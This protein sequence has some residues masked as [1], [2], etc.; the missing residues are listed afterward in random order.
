MT[1]PTPNEAD[2]VLDPTAPAGVRA[3]FIEEWGK[4][5]RTVR[6]EPMMRLFDS[7]EQGPN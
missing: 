6:M 7:E 1:S 5:S 3:S 2:P 4:I